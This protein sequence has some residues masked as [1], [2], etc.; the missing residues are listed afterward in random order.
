MSKDTGFSSPYFVYYVMVEKMEIKKKK[1][2]NGFLF[3]IFF[4]FMSL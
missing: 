1:K 2:P 4:L 3:L